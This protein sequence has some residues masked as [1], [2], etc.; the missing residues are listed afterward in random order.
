MGRVMTREKRE[1]IKARFVRALRSQRAHRAL[2]D[3]R[4][5]AQERRQNKRKTKRRYVVKD[6]LLE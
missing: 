2:T 6:S 1:A 3:Q 5:V 4:D